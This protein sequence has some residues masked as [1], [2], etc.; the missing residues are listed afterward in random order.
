MPR[1][2]VSIFKLF[3]KRRDNVLDAR[4][5]ALRA[6]PEPKKHRLHVSPF[7]QLQRAA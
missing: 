7:T 1:T 2:F 5:D 4:Y 3:S 6:S